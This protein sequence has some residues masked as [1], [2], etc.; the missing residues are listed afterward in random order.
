MDTYPQAKV[1]TNQ[2][3]KDFLKDLLEIDDAK[4]LTIG[5]KD[6]LSLGNKTLEFHLTPWVHWPETMVTYLKEDKILFSCDFFGSHYASSE[7]FVSDEPKVFSGA[8]RYFSEIMMPFRPQVKKNV[9]RVET[10]DLKMIAPSHG[11]VYK[12]PKAIIE[13]YKEWISDNVKKE[14]LIPYVSMHGS[15]LKMVN[16]LVDLLTEKGFIVKPFNLST[17]DI[18]NYAISLI[19][20]STIIVASPTVLAGP[21]PLAVYG[22]FL[23]N[24]LRPKTKFLTVVGS[25][26]WGGKMIETLKDMVSNLKVELIE[27]VLIKGVPKKSDYQLLDKLVLDLDKKHQELGIR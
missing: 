5:D 6:T 16:Y 10:L 7:L 27:P 25:F 21:H 4:F 11:Q 17:I 8:K 20:A 13:A 19:D 9:E 2:K 26:G 18:G 12:N 22:T 3:C 1:V 14:V 15:T 24:L 23:T